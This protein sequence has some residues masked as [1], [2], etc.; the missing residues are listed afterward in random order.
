MRRVRTPPPNP[1]HDPVATAPGTDTQALCDQNNRGANIPYVLITINQTRRVGRSPVRIV[2]TPW[3]KNN[4]HS[5]SSIAAH[6][7]RTE[8]R[9]RSRLKRKRLSN[10]PKQKLLPRS[11]ELK[12][13]QQNKARRLRRRHRRPNQLKPD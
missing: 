10:R 8:L 6:S 13:Q 5:K 3:L 9:A 7:T 1:N 11:R 4:Q 12:R 2:S